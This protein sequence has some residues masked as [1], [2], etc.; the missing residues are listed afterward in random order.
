VHAAGPSRGANFRH[1]VQRYGPF[2]RLI[3]GVHLFQVNAPLKRWLHDQTTL[4]PA[5]A[6]QDC[7]L[8]RNDSAA[9]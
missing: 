2:A 4:P 5:V 3:P 8:S 9:D 7:V 1:G 6:Q